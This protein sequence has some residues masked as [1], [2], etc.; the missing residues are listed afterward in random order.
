MKDLIAR[1]MEWRPVRAFLHYGQKKGELLGGGMTLSAFYSLFAALF[2]AFAMFAWIPMDS[3]SLRSQV[4]D[5]VD[6]AIPGLISMSPGDGGAINLDL[7][8]GS[9]LLGVA[10]LIAAVTL[11]L[12]A[13]AWLASCREGFRAIFGLE[14]PPQN[15]VMLKLID[16]ASAFGIGI[17]VLASSA[18]ILI[19]NTFLDLLGIGFMGAIAGIVAQLA[20]DTLIVFLLYRYVGGLRLRRRQVL[21]AAATCAFGFFVLKQIIGLL[22]GSIE[23]N[24][25]LGSI[26]S[27]VALLIWLGFIH[28][29]LLLVL[30]FVAVGDSAEA[31]RLASRTAADDAKDAKDAADSAAKAEIERQK[32]EH[33]EKFDP[34]EMAKS[35]F[36]PSKERDKLIKRLERQHKK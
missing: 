11:L 4:V 14:A 26:A 8:M 1:V 21:A 15:I 28:R 12:T 36:P 35:E 7:L 2:V 32:R 25:L 10:G 6:S 3:D 9:S 27:I 24:P 19:T 18:G 17:L 13:I 31:V 34:I 30:S 20:L 5:T 22:L 29:I 23:R 16:L 33:G